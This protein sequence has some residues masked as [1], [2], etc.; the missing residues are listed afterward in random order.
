VPNIAADILVRTKMPLIFI[1]SVCHIITLPAGVVEKYCDEYVCVCVCLCLHH[2]L[3]CYS[4]V[5]I[6]VFVHA[7]N[8]FKNISSSSLSSSSM[9]KTLNTI[10]TFLVINWPSSL[11]LL[12]VCPVPQK[13]PFLLLNNCI[14]AVK[15]AQSTDLIRTNHPIV[16]SFLH[17]P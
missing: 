5:L 3:C 7:D 6:F 1:L 2:T 11:N 4:F 14:K 8:K 15:E 16:S 12:E 13:T 9:R 17:L 10:H